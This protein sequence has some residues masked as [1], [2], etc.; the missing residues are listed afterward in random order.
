MCWSESAS[1]LSFVV[2]SASVVLACRLLS[3]DGRSDL[4]VTLLAWQF[5]LLMQIPEW[6]EWRNQRLRV[7]SPP[8]VALAA[9]WLNV[10]QPLA[11]VVAVWHVTQRPPVLAIGFLVVYAAL[12]VADWDAVASAVSQGIAPRGSCPHLNLDDWWTHT[13][14]AVYHA[15]FVAAVAQ[16]PRPQMLLNLGIFELTFVYAKFFVKCGTSSVWCWSIF[17]AAIATILSWHRGLV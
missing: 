1:I 8:G 5:A 9:F 13:R 6:M 17:V 11:P 10:L 4:V 16:L 7:R 2:G 15:V 3:V 14:C 12:F